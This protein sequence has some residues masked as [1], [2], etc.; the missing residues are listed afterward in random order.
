MYS[1]GNFQSAKVRKSIPLL[2]NLLLKY[3]KKYGIKPSF[4]VFEDNGR[5]DSTISS[6]ETQA[7]KKRYK[8]THLTVALTDETKVV[9]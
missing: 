5:F 1:I 7:N 6:L 8:Q 3:R 9:L 4:F 2:V